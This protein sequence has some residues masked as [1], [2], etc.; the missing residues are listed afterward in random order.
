MQYTCVPHIY[1]VH[2]SCVGVPHFF[3]V[4]NTSL[5]SPHFNYS[6]II[7]HPPPPPPQECQAV[8]TEL[9]RTVSE[10]ESL[11]LKVQE[12]AQSLLR[13]E[14]AIAVK[15]GENSELVESYR[16]LEKERDGAQMETRQLRAERKSLKTGLKNLQDSKHAD[17]KSIED[18]CAELQ[19]QLDNV[20]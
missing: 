18:R 8:R 11:S 15:K 20:S 17:L 16:Q 3:L 19:L 1:H 12:Y 6:T 14:E 13:A 2:S 9:Q 7:Y 10:K 5:I 4:C